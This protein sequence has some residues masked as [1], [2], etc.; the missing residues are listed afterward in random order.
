MLWGALVVGVLIIAFCMDS[1]AG[2]VILSCGVAAIGLAALS[3]ITGF[4]IFWPLAKVCVVA[5]V[6]I[7][8][9]TIIMSIFGK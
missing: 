5:L 2:K 3:W 1:T 7:L 4:N 8:V 9:A 6:I